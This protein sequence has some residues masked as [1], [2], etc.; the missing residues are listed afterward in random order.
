MSTKAK[1][2]WAVGVLAV[3]SSLF[4][5][6]WSVAT[7]REY[8]KKWDEAHG[9]ATGTVSRMSLDHPLFRAYSIVR[10][11]QFEFGPFAMEAAVA[12]LDGVDYHRY[13]DSDDDRPFHDLYQRATIGLIPPWEDHRASQAMSL[14]IALR[15][16]V[17]TKYADAPFVQTVQEQWE[18]WDAGRLEKVLKEVGP[19]P[20]R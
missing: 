16:F 4:A 15:D 5:W 19:K 9:R 18:S 2:F 10:E 6:W 7:R 20:E 1:L 3:A 13:R 17:R 14:A 11:L 12:E 8:E